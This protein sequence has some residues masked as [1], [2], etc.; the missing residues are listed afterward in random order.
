MLN[1]F[2]GGDEQDAGDDG[3]P[4]GVQEKRVHVNARRKRVENVLGG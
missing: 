3:D 4:Y 1:F 2:L